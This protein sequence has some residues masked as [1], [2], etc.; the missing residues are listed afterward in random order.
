MFE[1]CSNILFFPSPAGQS[2]TYSLI[3]KSEDTFFPVKED[4]KGNVLDFLPRPLF[5]MYNDGRELFYIPPT[6]R[7]FNNAKDYNAQLTS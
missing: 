6:P 2:E 3:T 5:N 1:Y 4:V 7:N